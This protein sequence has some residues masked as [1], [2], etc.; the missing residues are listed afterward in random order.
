MPTIFLGKVPS[1]CA[2]SGFNKM[3]RLH[4]CSISPLRRDAWRLPKCARRS[5]GLQIQLIEMLGVEM[6]EMCFVASATLGKVSVESKPLPIQICKN[7]R[8]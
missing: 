7:L 2:G 3:L 4:S 1:F 5:K 6:M 8:D